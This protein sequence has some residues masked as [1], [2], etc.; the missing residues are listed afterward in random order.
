MND[1]DQRANNIAHAL[2][3]KLVFSILE[4]FV[5]FTDKYFLLAVCSSCRENGQGQISL[6]K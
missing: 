2:T 5:V 1:T 4:V 6:D 3:L